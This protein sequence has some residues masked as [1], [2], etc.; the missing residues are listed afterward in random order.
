MTAATVSGFRAK[1][2]RALVTVIAFPLFFLLNFYCHDYWSYRCVQMDV[3]NYK[4]GR[5]YFL[6]ES[7]FF[8]S[9]FCPKQTTTPNAWTYICFKQMDSLLAS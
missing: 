4:L 1:L 3:E 5:F 6:T 2:N 9:R 8:A 7:C